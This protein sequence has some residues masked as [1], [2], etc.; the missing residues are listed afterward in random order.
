MHYLCY[1][2]LRTCSIIRSILGVA[3]VVENAKFTTT[4]GKAYLEQCGGRYAGT[5]RIGRHIWTFDFD[6]QILNQ[7][8]SAD[9][10]RAAQESV[11]VN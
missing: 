5:D 10:A 7:K 9:L 11:P 4:S 8:V 3:L 6:D 1:A 2:H